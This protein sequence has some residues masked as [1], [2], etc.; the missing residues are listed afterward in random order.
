MSGEQENGTCPYC[1]IHLP[2]NRKYYKYDI[3]CDCCNSKEDDHFE[4]ILHCNTCKPTP[5][6][7]IIVSMQPNN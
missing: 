7:R 2:L 5:P 1:N 3:K 4:I 6:K